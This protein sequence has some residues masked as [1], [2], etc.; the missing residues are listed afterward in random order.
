MV[1]ALNDLGFGQRV[2]RSAASGARKLP[3]SAA[4]SAFSV[5]HSPAE[6]SHVGPLRRNF[7]KRPNAAIEKPTAAGKKQG[8]RIT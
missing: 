5:S 2:L 4:R 3:V 1:A 6:P 7:S 8:P